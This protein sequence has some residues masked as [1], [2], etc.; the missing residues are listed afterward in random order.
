M[1]QSAVSG[2][3]ADLEGQFQIRLFDRVGKRLKLSPLGQSL[4]PRGEALQEQARD[5]ARALSNESDVGVLRVGATL[6]IGNYVAA[7]LMA[8]FMRAHAGT[9]VELAIANTTEI[10]RRVANFEIDVGLIEGELHDSSLRVTPWCQDELVVF[11]APE[12]PFAAIDPVSDADLVT[13]RWIVREPGSGT[14]QAFE[15]AMHGI[16]SDV[17]IALELQHTEAIKSAVA[18]G[19]GLGC[20]SRLA[21]SESF[22]L[23]TLVPCNIVGR[24]F[25][26]QF[27]FVLHEQKYE[28]NA[29]RRW[30][31]LCRSWPASSLQYSAPPP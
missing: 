9:K 20:V 4:R 28:T 29:M 7:P 14:R 15:R 8:E 18:A 16:L 12:H 6:T 17:D 3:L 22:R 25:Q 2:S 24:D 13:A 5:L 10:A 1:S 19:L 11:C 23:G 30:L 26:R 31:N 21:L 27:F